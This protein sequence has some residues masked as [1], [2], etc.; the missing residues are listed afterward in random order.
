MSYSIDLATRFMLIFSSLFVIVDP[1]AIVP[2]F[3]SLT[4]RLDK[5]EIESVIRRAC[6]TG[7]EVLVFFHL[8][9]LIIFQVLGIQLEAFKIAGGILLFFTAMDMLKARDM[10]DRYPTEVENAD[11]KTDISIVPLAMPLLAGP[12]A[13]TS[14]I[15]YSNDAK[16]TFVEN[17][18]ISILAIS[19]VF[20][21]SYFVLKYS[22]WIKNFMGKSGIAIVQR[23]MGILLA[24][25]SVQLIVEGAAFLV[26][27]ILG[28]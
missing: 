22:I 18:I 5:A 21:L 1:F 7:A 28:L 26:K 13:I 19:L 9:G 4:K 24:A 20:L 6:L 3:L 8:F 27:K 2:T 16:S 14:V 12:G 17:T 10:D 25:L 11:T 15:V 23:V